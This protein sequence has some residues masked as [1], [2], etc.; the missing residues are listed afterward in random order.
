MANDINKEDPHYKG[1]YSS[2]YEVN[3]KFPTGGVAGD[4]VVIDVW[5]HYWNADRGTWCVNAERDS[6]WDELIT[7]VIEKFKLV[8]GATYMGVAS[9]DTVPAKAI[10]AKMYYFA[11]VAGKYKNFGDLVVPQGINVLYSENGSSWV[12]TTLLEVAQELGVS[13]NKVVSQKALND[14]LNLKANQSSVNEA[15]AKKA[16]KEEMNRLLSTKAN[17]ADVNTKFAEEKKRVD[18]ELDKKANA[19]EVNSSLK[20]LKDTDTQHE[21]RLLALEQSEWSL[22]LELSLTPSLL[23]Y[24]G[25]EKD[26]SVSWKVSRK[27]AELMPTALAIKQDG[28]AQTAGLA[29]SGSINAK[30]NK[31]G[32]TL[33]EISV[34]ADSMQ[35]TVVSKLTMVLPIYCGFGTSE[36]DVAVDANKLSP[37]I[38]ANG[39]Y[40]KTS[41]KDN[42]NFIIL[43]PK[44]LPK[45][46]SFT[47]GGAQFVM[48][49]LSVVINS[50]DYYMYKSGGI[51]MSGTEVK[52]QAS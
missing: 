25:S 37:R 52:V 33:F 22:S 42:V 17:T 8:R 39:T 26:V 12:N 47:M 50:H 30:V 10:G 32:D 2:I 35:K 45:L 27:G 18:A 43:V 15:L 40:A 38:S 51:Y 21:K 48:N 9:L 46:S 19:V 1:E 41:A 28:V 29:A 23:E 24:T 16:D 7:N 20:D 6:Y 36:T 3:R 34:T 5:A 13:T 31:L 49:T 4:F 14:A 44:T 11:T